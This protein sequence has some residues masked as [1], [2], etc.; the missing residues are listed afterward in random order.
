LNSNQSDL[1]AEILDFMNSRTGATEAI[2]EYTN[3]C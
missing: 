2:L 1:K 3:K